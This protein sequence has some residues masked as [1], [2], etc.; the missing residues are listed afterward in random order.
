MDSLKETPRGRL[1]KQE[2]ID[3]D[4]HVDKTPSPKYLSKRPHRLRLGSIS[5]ETSELS[6]IS[7][8]EIKG[9]TKA[10]LL[11]PPGSASAKPTTPKPRRKFVRSIIILY[12]N[13]EL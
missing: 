9:A 5:S 10:G 8:D 13:H 2:K 4:G 11:P 6:D 1:R 3:G 7:D 12:Y